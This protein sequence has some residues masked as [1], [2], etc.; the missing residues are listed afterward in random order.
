M[1]L[2]KKVHPYCSLQFTGKPLFVQE[3]LRQREN[4]KFT[5]GKMPDPLATR[6]MGDDML[7]P[8]TLCIT[9][10]LDRTKDSSRI[11][12]FMNTVCSFI[13]GGDTEKPPALALPEQ[14]RIDRL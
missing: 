12:F 10:L 3:G 5:L 14:P 9:L 4:R 8:Q 13:L 6:A 2:F 11:G 7:D 1:S